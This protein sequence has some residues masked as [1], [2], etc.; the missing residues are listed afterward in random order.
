VACGRGRL[1]QWGDRERHGDDGREE[2][3]H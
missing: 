1:S 3:S 2:Q